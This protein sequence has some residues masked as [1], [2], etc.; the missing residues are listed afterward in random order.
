[1]LQSMLFYYDL[2]IRDLGAAFLCVL[3]LYLFA[4]RGRPRMSPDWRRLT[5]LLPSA[6][7]LGLYAMV[8]VEG[9]YVGVF[10]LLIGLDVLTCLRLPQAMP[11]RLL[12]IASGALVA[13]LGA[14]LVVFHLRGSIALQQNPVASASTLPGQASPHA[15]AASLRAMGV[16]PG[17]P[18]GVIGYVFD[19]FWARAAGVRL[20]A[21]LR[22]DAAADL[23]RSDKGMDER[24]LRA[25]EAAGA[26]AIVAE[27]VP[28]REHVPGWQQVGTT[29]SYVRLVACASTVECYGRRRRCAS[30]PR[31]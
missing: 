14:A 11:R 3:L 18:V 9:R 1:L 15:I 21:E 10:V 24:V 19:A 23:W 26:K 7:A 4:V 17:D 13:C 27:Y 5:L 30:W 12:T 31:F 16:E 6:V 29:S 8:Y 28:P 22:P 2:F 20:V 25:F